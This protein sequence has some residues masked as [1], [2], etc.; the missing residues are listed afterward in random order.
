MASAKPSRVE[1]AQTALADMAGISDYILEHEGGVA[2]E[3]VVD[4]L[5][6]A[7]GRLVHAPRSGRIVPELRDQYIER[8]REVIHS[9][10]RIIYSVEKAKVIVI[11]IVDGRRNFPDILRDRGLFGD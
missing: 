7:V 3:R 8:Y 9:P 1:L 11:A 4:G 6:V 10:W 5:W 2:A